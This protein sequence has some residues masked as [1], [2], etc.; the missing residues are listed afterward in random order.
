MTTVTQEKSDHAVVGTISPRLSLTREV[1][2]NILSTAFDGGMMSDWCDRCYSEGYD[3]DGYVRGHPED[4]M[5]EYGY[6][7]V[8]RGGKLIIRE[9]DWSDGFVA[10]LIEAHSLDMAKL[11]TGI[12]KYIAL[13]NM[14]I[15]ELGRFFDSGMDAI[16]ACNIIE[17]AIFG[18]VRYC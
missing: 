4:D 17:C 9:V 2:D 3:L 14:D 11:I 7:A 8:A 12:E 1:V 18:E 5:A 10:S 6:A 13:E 15:E 16:D